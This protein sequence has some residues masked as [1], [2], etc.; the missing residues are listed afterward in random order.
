[1]SDAFA[2]LWSS[3]APPTQKKQ[4]LQAYQAASNPSSRPITPGSS[5]A[6]FNSQPRHTPNYTQPPPQH[7]P[8]KPS[9][10]PKPSSGDPFGA[11]LSGNL[12][13]SGGNG[14]LTMAEMAAK[15][16]Q[17]RLDRHLNS[18]NQAAGQN[19]AGAATLWAGLDVLATPSQTPSPPVKAGSSNSLLDDADDWGFGST[20]S[21]R[22][23]KVEKVPAK[24]VASTS[25]VVD[26]TF[27]FDAFDA[28]PKAPPKVPSVVP[29]SKSN[30]NVWD[31]LDSFADSPATTLA[32]QLVHDDADD[33]GFGPIPT[34]PPQPV[35]TTSS[36]LQRADSPSAD[37]DFG[38]REYDDASP[39]PPAQQSRPSRGAPSPPP[40]I[41]GQMVEMGFAP[42][43]AKVALINTYKEPESR[44]RKDAGWDVEGAVS[45]LINGG[46]GSTSHT[47][48][49]RRA[50]PDDYP[51]RSTRG[52]PKPPTRND[53]LS[54][55]PAAEPP[56]QS[57]NDI[58]AQ[59]SGLGISMF[60]RANAFWNTKGKEMKD[61][62]VERV[63]KVYEET[64]GAARTETGS[65]RSSSTTRP[66]WMQDGP[67]GLEH[68][69]IP[70]T[71]FKDDDEDE[72]VHQK[73]RQPRR[74]D[75]LNT[76]PPEQPARPAPREVDL[77]TSDIPA[78]VYVSPFRRGKPKAATPA[79]AAVAAPSLPLRNLTPPPLAPRSLL[80][81]CSPS[82]ISQSAKFKAQGTEYFKLG[83]YA[84]AHAMY[85]RAIEALPSGHLCR[86]P[87]YNNRSLASSR[88]GDVKGAVTDAGRA[89]GII[90]G[91]PEGE[92]NA[93]SGLDGLQEDVTPNDR[94]KLLFDPRKEA[95][96][97]KLE[98][99]SEVDLGAAYIKATKRRAESYEGMEKWGEAKKDWELLLNTGDWVGES[100]RRE[101][102]AAVGRC[103]K[104]LEGPPKSAAKPPSRP[105]PRRPPPSTSKSEPPSAALNALRQ[106]NQQ[107]ETE[108][109]QRH[110]LKDL[111][112]SRLMAW[113]GGKETN[114]RALIASLENVLWPELGWKKVGMNELVM[115]NQVKIRYVRAIA[116]VHPDKLTPNNTTLEQRMIA[117]GV[118]GALN[119]AWN[120]FK[121]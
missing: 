3:T 47:P 97:T 23:S 20:T 32:T 112:D 41:L 12:G 110:E 62:V 64:A 100:T 102:V 29:T 120:A 43:K 88:N 38:S 108:A 99:G 87:L 114:I 116:K 91:I 103:R 105:P 54:R 60:N 83:Q 89:L 51:S 34:K 61:K 45:S 30:M 121:P 16:Q 76:V 49:P 81:S 71:S 7:A 113:K 35:A 118:F 56:S 77:F 39:A 15:A 109:N 80:V 70:P 46:G 1:M 84:E 66:K 115:E 85:T 6:L 59:A 119:E 96:V 90:C 28:T 79:P 22:S 68:S 50:S 37:F 98:E 36:T 21:T 104:M 111:V 58:L 11:L 69:D 57:S 93:L 94:A 17:E 117:N 9:V 65:S 5:S 92:S 48:E 86:V 18:R 63:V 13:S 25:N 2:D 8:P 44:A 67:E 19:G 107:A 40:H 42:D 53:S 101:A 26:D 78:N 55:V 106:A 14:R 52:R 31:A 73:P 4:P 74:K 27:S 75:P 24:P 10:T 72:D 95:K 82:T 33:L